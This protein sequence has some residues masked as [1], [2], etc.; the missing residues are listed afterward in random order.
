MSAQDTFEWCVAAVVKRHNAATE[1]FINEQREYLYT[2]RSEDER[3][4]FVE[5]VIQQIRVMEKQGKSK[6]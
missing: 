4:R 1:T 2:L 5:G 6:L 3:Q